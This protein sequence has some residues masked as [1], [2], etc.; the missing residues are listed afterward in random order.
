MTH[1]VLAATPVVARTR[2]AQA[3]PAPPGPA[4]GC[5]QPAGCCDALWTTSPAGGFPGRAGGQISA[6]SRDPSRGP[7]R[8]W[9]APRR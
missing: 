2:L 9:R 4:L 8:T 7:A 3:R 5:G 6:G 1:L